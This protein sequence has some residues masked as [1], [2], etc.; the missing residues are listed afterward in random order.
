MAGHCPPLFKWLPEPS[1]PNL[2]A[3]VLLVS[4]L[5]RGLEQMVSRDIGTR[6]AQA[7][8]EGHTTLL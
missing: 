4:R 3:V 2:L 5:T 7:N 8:A 1:P 6:E